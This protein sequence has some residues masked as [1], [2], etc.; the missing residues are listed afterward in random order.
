MR[1]PA[2]PIR[3]ILTHRRKRRARFGL[4]W[5]L[6]ALLVLATGVFFTV[7]LD[8]I[9]RV[10]LALSQVEDL[11]TLDEMDRVLVLA[12]HPDDEV[13]CTGGLIQSAIA[14]GA[15][16]QVVFLTLG[17]SNM[18]AFQAYERRPVVTPSQ[19]RAMGEI[20]R[21]EALRSLAL[22]GVSADRVRFLGYP[23]GGI[24]RIWESHWQ[25][26]RPLRTAF[27]RV[28]RVPYLETLSPGA[29]YRGESVL[30]DLVDA[31]S[32]FAPTVIFVSHP[33]D[34]N[35]DHRGLWLFTH[36]ALAELG[37]SFEDVQVWTSL[38]HY[39][40]WPPSG[41]EVAG[42]YL[43]PPEQLTGPGV[44][45]YTLIL[46]DEQLQSK[47]AAL[48]E[49]RTQVS[50][51]RSYLERF[52]R[53]NELFARIRP[54][55]LAAPADGVVSYASVTAPR[56]YS[57]LHTLTP[58]SRLGMFEVGVDD[59]DLIVRLRAPRPLGPRE[60]VTL[61]L[62]YQPEAGRFAGA[63]KLAV[64]VGRD[65]LVAARDGGSDVRSAVSVVASGTETE[66]RASLAALGRPEYLFIQLQMRALAAPL[67]YSGWRIIDLRPVVVPEEADA[68]AIIAHT[69]PPAEEEYP[70]ESVGTPVPGER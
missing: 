7:E 58:T 8:P 51:R 2:S 30:Q 29:E 69:D 46:T 47:R 12:P 68:V 16:V 60:S 62:F 28:D 26:S 24:L 56:R 40:S 13:L 21:T 36:A 32:S 52:V 3:T 45:W 61:L 1:I 5:R 65:G 67:E 37:P 49:H 14:A 55:R 11:P 48:N 9:G 63:S 59:G 17:D 33:D 64:T 25:D 53:P 6:V 18:A 4:L 70:G 44:E 43:F 20:R 34:S 31:I 10:Q 50:F 22:L 23:D 66:M 19:V 54:A 27:T 42:E 41:A 38:V 15:E 57:V 39:G 35:V